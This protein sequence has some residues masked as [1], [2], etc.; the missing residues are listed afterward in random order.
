MPPVTVPTVQVNVLGAVALR[1]MLVAVLLQIAA[2]LAVVTAGVGLTVTVIVYGAPAQVVLAVDVGVTI[3]STVPAVTLLGLLNICPIVL[4]A[5][6]VAPVIPP[7]IVPI[8]QVNVLGA[9]D[10]RV[11][12]VDVALQIA[13]VFAVVTAGVGLT[14]TVIVYG[15]PAHVVLAVDVGVTMYCTVPA[16]ALLGL[17]NV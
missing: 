5:P 15:E 13:F 2:V 17:V 6:A 16:V 11:M 8:V 14:A 7:V 1:L 3:Y 10:V 9:V 12:L 4:P